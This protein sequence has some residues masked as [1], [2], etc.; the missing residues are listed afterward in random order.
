L[1]ANP[2]GK[3]WNDGVC[4]LATAIDYVCQA[5]SA[6][7]YAH[8]HHVTHRD[9]TPGNMLVT[10]SGTIKLTDFGLAKLPTDLRLTKTGMMVGSLYYMSPEQV[11]AVPDVD[12][13]SDLYSVGAVL[14]EMVTG[15]RPFDGNSAFAIMLAQVG[16]DPPAPI[17]LEP[18]LPLGLNELILRALAKDPGD[19]FQS[20]LEFR[21]ALESFREREKESLTGPA[22]MLDWRVADLGRCRAE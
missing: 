14:Y 15:A 13:R 17:S 19:R 10:S 7:A 18:A 8:A 20:A 11:R 1:K 9:I 4:Q 5:L 12:P 22:L 21:Q 3:F 16:Q 6:L 2:C